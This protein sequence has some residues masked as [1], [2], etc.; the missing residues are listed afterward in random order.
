MRA[1][2]SVPLAVLAGLLALWTGWGLYVRRTTERVPYETVERL[3]GA[4]LRR[5]PRSVLVETTADDPETA[6]R[7]LFRYLSGANEGGEDVAM[8]APV[9]TRG[10][11]AAA[12]AP[13]RA[14]RDEGATVSLTAPVR[15]DRRGDAAT[16]AF[17]LPATYTPESAPVPT[18]PSVRLVV[19]PERTVAGRRFS[20]FATDRR[21][22]REE[23]RLLDALAASGIEPQDEPV[24]LRYDDPWTPPFVGTNEVA[25][26]VVDAGSAGEQ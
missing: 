9:A 1:R 10:G 17:F 11:A 20:W 18:D 25:V 2:S 3:A 7:R 4:E 14:L 21:V 24:L 26:P 13:V 15:T 22:A 6:F 8:T 19:E 23:R 12:T 16:M 5:Y